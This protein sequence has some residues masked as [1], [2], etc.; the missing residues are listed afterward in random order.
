MDRRL[1]VIAV[2]L[3]LPEPFVTQPGIDTQRMEWK[4]LRPFR[5]IDFV[6]VDDSPAVSHQNFLSLGFFLRGSDSHPDQPT[7]RFRK[8]LK[9]PHA[10]PAH[11][12]AHQKHRGAS[13]NK[14]AQ[15]RKDGNRERPHV[16][17]DIFNS[18]FDA[19]GR[20]I[21]LSRIVDDKA[22]I[23]H[24][25]KTSAQT[26]EATHLQHRETQ[27]FLVLICDH[28][29]DSADPFVLVV[30]DGAANHLAHPIAL[31]DDR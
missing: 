29:I 27:L 22:V 28:I 3:W 1:Q 15:K 12:P 6:N 11:P 14:P 17:R 5:R 30:D 13:Y 24:R 20:V 16:P 21:F 23:W 8:L 18:S 26:E 31:R 2:A 4:I 9:S 25:H 7:V 19:P 10:L